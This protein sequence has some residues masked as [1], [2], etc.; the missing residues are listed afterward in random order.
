MYID[1]DSLGEAA[2]YRLLS[3][4]VVPRPIAWVT[5]GVTADQ[6]NLAPFSSFA[7]VSTYPAMLGFNI[8]P[9][10]EGRK[11]TAR[12]IREAGEYVVNIADYSMLEAVHSSSEGFD[13]EVSEVDELG[14]ETIAS[15]KV[16]PPRLAAAPVSM[17]CVLREV[18]QFGTT[19]SEFFVG[20]VVAFHVQ[21]RLYD[22]G[23]IDAELFQPLARL[24]GPRYATL[25]GIRTMPVVPGG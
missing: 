12:N 5:S 19:G 1:A 25:A 13:V 16:R 2:T 3:G 9:R 22:A 20:E 11:D 24:G 21:D 15:T 7:W 17:E 18:L 14:L 23:K 10:G 6:V 4:A 8:A